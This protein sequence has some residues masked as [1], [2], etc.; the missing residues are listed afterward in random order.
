MLVLGGATMVVTL[1]SMGVTR[2]IVD[3]RKAS[4][5]DAL[6]W[7]CMGPEHAGHT[8]QCLRTRA[9]M[10]PQW[11]MQKKLLVKCSSCHGEAKVTCDVCQG[12][13]CT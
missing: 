8:I 4:G 11:C 12:A 13:S 6:A 2:T 5:D 7:Q 9:C 10:C 1:V 3:K